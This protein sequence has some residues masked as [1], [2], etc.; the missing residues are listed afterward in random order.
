[1]TVNKSE[2]DK[3]IEKSGVSA[4]TAKKLRDAN[5]PGSGSPAVGHGA[6]A[7]DQQLVT[8]I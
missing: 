8:T 7:E 1:M 6:P 2:L 3:L 4:R 5:T